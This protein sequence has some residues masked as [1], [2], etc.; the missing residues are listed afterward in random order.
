MAKREEFATLEARD[1]AKEAG[2]TG[3]TAHLIDRPG[4]G[5]SETDPA[6]KK[7]KQN[8][9]KDGPDRPPKP[10]MKLRKVKRV[11]TEWAQQAGLVKRVF[12]TPP[13]SLA[14][15]NAWFMQKFYNARWL[16]F[17]LDP[18]D[19]KGFRGRSSGKGYA[20]LDEAFDYATSGLY[21][22]SVLVVVSK[23]H[24]YMAHF[25][26]KPGFQYELERDVLDFVHKSQTWTDNYTK[27]VVKWQPFSR[28]K[29]LYENK[30]HG[31]RAFIMAPVARDSTDPAGP[32]RYPDELNELH[33]ELDRL[34]KGIRFTKVGYVPVSGAEDDAHETSGSGKVLF[35]Y[36]PNNGEH[37]GKRVASARLFFDTRT[38]RPYWQMDWP[39]LEAQGGKSRLKSTF[40]K[41]PSPE[42][43][44]SS[45]R[46]GRGGGTKV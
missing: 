6:E 14:Q 17:A 29:D 18:K 22:C 28:Y 8:H 44:S 40:E 35:Q 39:A 24:V 16:N 33:R 46:R 7:P 43:E 10:S 27:K 23:E 20:L 5:Y 30:Y 21:G 34:I 3:S 12:D 4:C 1:P 38:P 41:S 31:T 19:K 26:E 42:P 25:W 37:K 13:R 45:G 32:L 9:A 2:N 11:L 36:D 15:F